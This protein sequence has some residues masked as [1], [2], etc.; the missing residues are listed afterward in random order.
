ME[1]YAEIPFSESS[2][3]LTD[4]IVHIGKGDKQMKQLLRLIE[5][6]DLKGKKIRII[7]NRFHLTAEEMGDLYRIRWKIETFFRWV[8]QH[9]KLTCLYGEAENAVWE[10]NFYF[11]NRLLFNTFNA[12]GAQNHK[13]LVGR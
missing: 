6:T 5:T 12:S 9:L 8:K 10:S 3:I 1:T 2:P 13:N 4:R 11:P 7:S